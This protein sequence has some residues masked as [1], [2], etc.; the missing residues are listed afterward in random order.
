MTSY[1]L[2]TSQ[3]VMLTS[4]RHFYHP[5]TKFVK[6]MFLHLSVSHSAHRGEY[7]SRYPPG[8]G[9]PPMTRYTPRTRYTLWDQVHPQGQV[10]LPGP[11]TPPRTR[12]S[13]RTRYNPRQVHPS[14]TRY[15]PWV[16]TNPWVGTPPPG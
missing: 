14:G 4:C 16:G 8:V 9:T 13:P 2:A 12:Y 1:C 11:G 6:V 15:T 3:H 5:Q 10:H 7:L